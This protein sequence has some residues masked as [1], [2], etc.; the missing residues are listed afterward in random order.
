MNG[1]RELFIFF[2]TTYYC[3]TPFLKIFSH[4]ILFT[5]KRARNEL[6]A[7][8]DTRSPA[9]YG[10]RLV[11]FIFVS[12]HFFFLLH[13]QLARLVWNAFEIQKKNNNNTFNRMKKTGMNTR[14]YDGWKSKHFTFSPS[15]HVFIRDFSCIPSIPNEPWWGNPLRSSLDRF[16]L[17]LF[18]DNQIIII[19]KNLQAVVTR[20]ES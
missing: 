20:G 4:T 16:L 18:R 2:R 9:V 5:T 6:T 15:N 19:K 7:V 13:I 8:F 17:T 1:H 12:F 11:V 3:C 14:V 10:G